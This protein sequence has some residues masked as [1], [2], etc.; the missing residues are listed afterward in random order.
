MVRRNAALALVRFHDASGIGEIRSMLQ[1][2]TIV[3]TGLPMG[4]VASV[5]SATLDERLKPGDMINPGTLI[6]RIDL[7]DQSPIELRSQVPGT[8]D[9]WLLPNK[10]KVRPFQPILSV[11]PSNDEIWEAL[12]ALYLIGDARD[13]PVLDNIARGAG[14]VPLRVRQQAEIAA[15][16]IRSRLAH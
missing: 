1:P 3:A 6:G 15:S 9:H 11:D 13:L 4:A 7:P 8:I 12:R 5:L 10:A 2:Y 14:D 16:A